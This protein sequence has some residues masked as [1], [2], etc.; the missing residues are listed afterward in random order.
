MSLRILGVLALALP[1]APAF[2][3]VSAEPAEAPA[4]AHQVIRFRIGHGCA[5]QA[6]TALRVEIPAGL[7]E[8]RPQPK[9]GWSL[10][11]ERAAGPDRVS[12]ITWTGVL[13]D[14]Q[15]DDFAIL[16]RLPDAPGP[17]YFPTVQTC[18]GEEAQ[19]TG[20]P[21]PGEDPHALSHP[22]PI[23]HIVPASGPAEM[24]HH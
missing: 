1:A 2:A 12:A 7:G 11:I 23:V 20:V 21:D 18:G 10:K 3:H 22:A 8:P 14:D 16:A 6:T 4:G 24:H 19:W 17:L 13:P 5:G 15:F 9:P